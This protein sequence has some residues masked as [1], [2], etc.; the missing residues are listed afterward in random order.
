MGASESFR[1]VPPSTFAIDA[2]QILF[3]ING[4]ITKRHW[5]SFLLASILL[6]S[7]GSRAEVRLH[8]L[9]S[10]NMVLQQGMAVPVWGWAN[11]GEV[12][13]VKFRGQRAS[14]KAKD[15]KWSL[16]L[17]SLKAGGPAVLTVRTKSNTIQ[18][19]NVLV[20][21]VWVCSGQSNMEFPLNTAY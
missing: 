1:P 17:R 16:K 3:W 8:G 20:G 15:G 13:T 10:D 12:V 19:T 7:F 11:D 14:T 18:V 9:F 2:R 6:A 21:E 5:F 4:M